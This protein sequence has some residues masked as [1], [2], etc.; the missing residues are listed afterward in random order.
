MS[1]CRCPKCGEMY[2]TSYKT[3][4]FCE[5][6]EAWAEGRAVSRKGSGRRVASRREPSILG[7]LLVVIILILAGILTYFFFGDKIAETLGLG[8]TAPSSAVEPQPPSTGS[9]ANGGLVDPE[10]P[11]IVPPSTGDDST[12][13]EGTTTPA[14]G[15]EMAFEDVAKLPQTLTLNSK[16]FSRD[17]SEG[18]WQ[19]KV[20]SGET[21]LS[22]V[23]ED[24]GI[25]S[26]DANGLVTPISKGTV[27]VMA[28]T[29][30]GMGSC[31]VRVTGK[32][33]PASGGTG[34]AVI[35]PTTPT[36]PV[37]PTTPNPA[38]NDPKNAK[39]NYTDFSL[40]LGDPPVQMKVTGVTGTV[41]WSVDKPEVVTVS[42]TGL[43]TRV[44]KGMAIVTATF[45]GGKLTCIVRVSK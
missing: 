35:A 41:T 33:V 19:L 43:V 38:T 13:T 3:C 32:A 45:D 23:S 2:S 15:D 31:I 29:S 7:P 4:P 14:T 11:D 17:V 25:V 16:D 5:E 1:M 24:E 21:G 42:S 37:T 26:V 6:D 10:N 12:G 18:P 44:G 22:W 36:A 8:Q 34:D 9:S 40:P 39:L 30:T 28:Y 20:T 27:R